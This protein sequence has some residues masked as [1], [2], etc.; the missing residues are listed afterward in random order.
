MMMKLPKKNV[1][2]G[3]GKLIALLAIVAVTA[4]V[5]AESWPSAPS[6]LGFE[7]GTNCWRLPHALWRVED[8]AGRGGSKALVWENTDPKRYLFPRQTIALEVGG[9][10]R[11]GAGQGRFVCGQGWEASKA[12]GVAGLRQRRRQV[13][14]RGLRK[15]GR[16]A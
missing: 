11:Y 9:I 1:V 5:V 16:Q 10:Y 2:R 12:A 14:R 8:G 3:R 4:S 6:N 13:D 15:A 7:D